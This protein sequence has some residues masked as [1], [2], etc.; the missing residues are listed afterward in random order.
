[1]GCFTRI[2]N[3]FL[4]LSSDKE[5]IYEWGYCLPDC[6]T[7]EIRPVCQT[8]PTFPKT[9]E[10]GGVNY[11]TNIDDLSVNDNRLITLGVR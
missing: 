2:S 5:T 8:F 4:A 9:A 6:P 7:E 1:M 3:V 11:T 10:G